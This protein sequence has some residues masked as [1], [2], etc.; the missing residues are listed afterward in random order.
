MKDLGFH[1]ASALFLHEVRA[2]RANNRKPQKMLRWNQVSRPG[3]PKS[4]PTS[5]CNNTRSALRKDRQ[6]TGRSLFLHRNRPNN[7]KSFAH[8]LWHLLGAFPLGSGCCIA[9]I[10]G[11][12]QWSKPCLC[13][14][15]GSNGPNFSQHHHRLALQRAQDPG[16]VSSPGTVA[17]WGRRGSRL[18]RTLS[19]VVKA[20]KTRC[21]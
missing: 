4:R 18:G 19:S 21:L 3:S 6:P 7:T 16:F 14:K 10:D 2:N 9:R 13:G 11:L 1:H 8:V 20:V 12:G 15:C 17:P 5:L